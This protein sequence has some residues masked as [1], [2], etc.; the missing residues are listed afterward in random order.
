M[1]RASMGESAHR[2]QDAQLRHEAAQDNAQ[3][4]GQDSM[5]LQDQLGP[6]S[7]SEL[8]EYEADR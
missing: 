3:V 7:R 8:H 1:A 2:G 5:S 6:R 4:G